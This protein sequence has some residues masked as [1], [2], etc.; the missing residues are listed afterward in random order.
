MI[1]LRSFVVAYLVSVGA[2]RLGI[3]PW[4]A[5]LLAVA[6]AFVAE[7]WVMPVIRRCVKHA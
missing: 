5:L 2:I 3:L 7:Y 4:A 6:S 1:V